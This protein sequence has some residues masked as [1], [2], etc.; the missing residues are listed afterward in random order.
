MGDSS[1]LLAIGRITK[2]PGA[3]AGAIFMLFQL[4]SIE[5]FVTTVENG[6]LPPCH[7]LGVSIDIQRF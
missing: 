5:D 2:S 1:N 7:L 4:L 3:F 6:V